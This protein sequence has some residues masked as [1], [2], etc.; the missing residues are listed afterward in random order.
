MNI[1]KE[2]QPQLFF[3]KCFLLKYFNFFTC[4]TNVVPSFRNLIFI[5]LV[6]MRREYYLMHYNYIH[7]IYKLTNHLLRTINDTSIINLSPPLPFSPSPEDQS[8][9]RHKMH[10][11]DLAVFLL[12]AEPLDILFKKRNAKPHQKKKRKTTYW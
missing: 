5:Y 12:D 2:L 4:I 8:I 6:N 11:I 9:E 3:S 1:T 10:I 7:G